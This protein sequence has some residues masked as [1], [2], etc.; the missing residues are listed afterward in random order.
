M[1]IPFAACS[2]VKLCPVKALMA[3]LLSSDLPI[4]SHLFAYI[5]ASKVHILTHSSF[6]ARLKQVLKA[7]GCDPTNFIP[8]SFRCGRTSFAINSGVHPLFVKAR[9]DWTSNAFENYVFLSKANTMA[10][11]ID[12]SMSVAKIASTGR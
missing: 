10:T 4:K 2:D 11:A 3:H 8:H 5:Q 12:I 7:A 6:T 9:G 1:I